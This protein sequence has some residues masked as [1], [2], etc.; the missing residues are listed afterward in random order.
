SDGLTLP[1]SRGSVGNL[2][3]TKEGRM[4]GTSRTR[5]AGFNPQHIAALANHKP[6]DLSGVV[7]Y[8]LIS[9]PS[10]VFHEDL[11]H[12]VSADGSVQEWLD[13]LPRQQAANYLR[14]VS[15]HLARAHRQERTVG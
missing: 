8:D 10:K 12:P 11:G 6:Y 5:L 3:P 9:R 14:R 4:E 13:S 2:T 7:T 15:D 1:E